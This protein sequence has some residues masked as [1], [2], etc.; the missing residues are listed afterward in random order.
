MTTVIVFHA[1]PNPADVGMQTATVCHA[2]GGIITPDPLTTMAISHDITVNTV[3]QASVS[4]LDHTDFM[5]AAG[6]CR[7]SLKTSV[8]DDVEFATLT[9]I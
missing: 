6:N 9:N 5:A 3:D 1:V 2:A 4:E 7:Y 8:I